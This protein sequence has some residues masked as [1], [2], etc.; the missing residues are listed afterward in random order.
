[1][2]TDAAREETSFSTDNGHSDDDDER[3]DVHF[4]NAADNG[5]NGV[6]N[7]DIMVEAPR[8]DG[9]DGGDRDILHGGSDENE[10]DDEDFDRQ[11]ACPKN[12]RK[13]SQKSLLRVAMQF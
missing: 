11:A 2:A 10:N 12:K 4:G 6:G 7:G 8:H 5:G 13:R 1:M 9:C 3:I